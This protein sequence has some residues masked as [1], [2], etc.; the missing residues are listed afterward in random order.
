MHDPRVVA[1]YILDKAKEKKLVISNLV[2]QKLLYFAQAISLTERKVPLV[3]GCFE[4]W[5]FGPVHPTVNQVFKK[6]GSRPIDF[7]AKSF[8]PITRLETDLADLSDSD[9]KE[10]CDRVISQLRNVSPGQLVDI[11]HA[12]GGPWHFVVTSAAN[13]S[14]LGLRIPNRIIAERHSRLKISI[15]LA[16]RTGEPDEDAPFVGD[17]PRKDRATSDR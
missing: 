13:S 17:R 10:I 9:S 6:A 2:L 1:N 7:R 8:D 14:N 5:Q 4:A 3:S 16:P 15:G 12:E 11:T